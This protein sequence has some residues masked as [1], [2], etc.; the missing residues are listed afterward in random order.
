MHYLMTIQE[1]S[2]ILIHAREGAA[3]NKALFV[4]EHRSLE[5]RFSDIY[6]KRNLSFHM[7][8]R[9]SS[10]DI[11]RPNSRH[12]HTGIGDV[13]NKVLQGLQRHFSEVHISNIYGSILS[14]FVLGRQ[15]IRHSKAEENHRIIITWTSTLFKAMSST[16]Y[17]QD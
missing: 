8:Y 12:I 1:K 2:I 10:Y 6:A 15:S 14:I 4:P 5:S 13:L 17:L 11:P 7:F 9:P 16:R 3:A